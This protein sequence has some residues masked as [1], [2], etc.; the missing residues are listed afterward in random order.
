MK[1]NKSLYIYALF[2]LSFGMG[3]IE[4]LFNIKGEL[5]SDST[6]AIWGIVSIF[7]T[8]LWAYFDAD[9]EGFEKPFD[10][11]LLAYIFWPVAFPWY[12]VKTRGIEGLVMFV[13]FMALWFGPWLAGVVAYVYLAPSS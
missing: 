10:F 1:N 6:Q 11:G 8:I 3:L 2:L 12:L 13:G 5:A 9:T 7:L 4:V